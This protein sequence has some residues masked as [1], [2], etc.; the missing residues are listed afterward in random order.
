M[1]QSASSVQAIHTYYSTVQY[2]GRA[3]ATATTWRCAVAVAV[4][5]NGGIDRHRRLGKS[6]ATE[7]NNKAGADDRAGLHEVQF[8][9]LD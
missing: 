3:P 4:A 7:N 6:V 8:R 5:R 9:L 1:R 2:L